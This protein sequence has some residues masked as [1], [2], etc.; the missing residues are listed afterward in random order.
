[1]PKE[2][3]IE[4]IND[5]K[6]IS[7]TKREKLYEKIIEEAVDW[8]IGVVNQ[9]EIDEMNILNATKRAVTK[10]IKELKIKPD[11]LLIDALQEIDTL[12]IPYKGIVKGD[13][14][15]YS[16]AC[17]SIIAKVIRDRM[18]REYDEIYPGYGFSGHKGYGTK[19]HIQAIREKGI[20]EIHRTSFVKSFI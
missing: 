16:V 8:S 3:F 10:A 15:I 17:G 1:M 6:K 14:K 9:D 20:C 19:K 4:G 7:E 2:S 13:E 11:I 5:S 12:G 18:M